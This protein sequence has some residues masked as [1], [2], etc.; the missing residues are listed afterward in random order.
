MNTVNPNFSQN[1]H[2]LKTLH[3]V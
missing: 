2:N 3:L 1:K